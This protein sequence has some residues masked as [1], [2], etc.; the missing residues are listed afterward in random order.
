MERPHGV[1]AGA[2]LCGLLSLSSFVF[3]VLLLGGRSALS[4]GAWILGGG[5]EQLGPLAFLLQALIAFLLAVGLW[6]GWKWARPATLLFCAG[7]IV[8]A[9]PAM[10]SAVADLRL[11]NITREGLQIMARVIVIFYLSQEPVKDWFR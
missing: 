8:L 3:A 5:L 9:V 4:E 11:L 10:S 1:T 2:A 6:E 7:G